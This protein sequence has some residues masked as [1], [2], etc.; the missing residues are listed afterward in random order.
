MVGSTDYPL[1]ARRRNLDLVLFE[2]RRQAASE[3]IANFRKAQH[4]RVNTWP[5]YQDSGEAAA[6]EKTSFQL[7]PHDGVHEKLAARIRLKQAKIDS[8]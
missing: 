5:K 7:S 4:P 8:L 1:W 2:K 6:H 3:E